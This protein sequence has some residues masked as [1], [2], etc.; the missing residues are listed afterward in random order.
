MVRYQV[1]N[2]ENDIYIYIRYNKINITKYLTY[3]KMGVFALV[4]IS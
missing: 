3:D 1:N 2:F 4:I